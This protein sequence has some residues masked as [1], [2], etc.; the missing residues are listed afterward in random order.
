MKK[1]QQAKWAKKHLLGIEDLSRE[2][3]TMIL[4][5]AEG[6]KEV[7]KRPIPKVPTLRGKTIVNLFCENS[8]RTRASF[9]LAEKRL[10]ADTLNIAAAASSFSK[11]ETLK[12]TA[13]NLEAMNIDMIVMRHSCAGAPHFLSREVKAS[14]INAGDGAHE[15]P[16]QALLDAFTIREKKGAIK[17]LNIS[18]IGD[19][20]HSR[21]ARSNI[22]TLTRLGAKVTVCGPK[23]LIP[24]DI[25][26]L[27]V[28]VTYDIKEALK[29]ADAINV[30]RIQMER[31][32]QALFP[33][34]R[35][36]VKRFGI[37]K[38]RLVECAKEDLLIMHPG[39][40]NR[41]VELSQDVADSK[42][43]VILNQVTNGVAV[44]MAILFLVSQIKDNVEE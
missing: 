8:T 27:G 39:P 43:S 40:I 38:E 32:K 29:R 17:G 14:V 44:R 36:Y 41:G 42:Y 5:Q 37:T 35:E 19:I 15:H 10:S 6:F 22:W 7:L 25:E 31:Q 24:V 30:L 16:T 21:V 13:R 2:E 4:D 26:K 1:N 11:G 23:T 12:D 28:R 3:I 33:S 18:I 9:E 34:L 20:S